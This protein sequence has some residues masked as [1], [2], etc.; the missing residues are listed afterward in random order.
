M[1]NRRVDGLAGVLARQH[2]RAAAPYMLNID[3]KHSFN[4]Y[5]GR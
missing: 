5:L 4:M 3:H 2:D 1:V